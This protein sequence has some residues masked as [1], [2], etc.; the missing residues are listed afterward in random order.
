VI[1]K[2]T[3]LEEGATVVEETGAALIRAAANVMNPGFH[4]V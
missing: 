2:W 4:G 3:D 1:A